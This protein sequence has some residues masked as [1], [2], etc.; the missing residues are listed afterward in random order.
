MRNPDFENRIVKIIDGKELNLS[1]NESNACQKPEL[2]F[3]IQD[4]C[5]YEGDFATQVLKNKRARCDRFS[6]YVNCK[7][8]EPASSRIERLFSSVG[9]CYSELRHSMTP[10]LLEDHIFWTKT[11]D[12]GIWRP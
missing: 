10:V 11:S 8:L 9:F 12:S 3:E 2:P 6:S 1:S 5:A 7:F 4:A